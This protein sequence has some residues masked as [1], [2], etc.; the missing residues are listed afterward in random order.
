MQPIPE[1]KP[2]ETLPQGKL[3]RGVAT[4][5]ARHARGSSL[6]RQDVG[7]LGAAS[8]SLPGDDLEERQPADDLRMP[9]K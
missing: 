1:P 6:G 8:R 4:P 3:W 2:V 5:D 7:H 9:T